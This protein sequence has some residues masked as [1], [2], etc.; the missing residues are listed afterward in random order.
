MGAPLSG[1]ECALQNHCSHPSAEKTIIIL[2]SPSELA[3]FRHRLCIRKCQILAAGVLLIGMIN[4]QGYMNTYLQ[5]QKKRKAKISK[6][7]L[8]E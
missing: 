8:R 2:K 4:Q 5:G 7:L 6:A 3:I 1:R